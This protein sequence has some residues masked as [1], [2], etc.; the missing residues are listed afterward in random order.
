MGEMEVHFRAAIAA[1]PNVVPVNQALAGS[2][3]VTAC[4][5]GR[6][7][8]ETTTFAPVEASLLRNLQTFDYR[9]VRDFPN[10]MNE[11]G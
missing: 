10:T 5:G 9:K 3:E 1:L 8:L 2:V 7:R 6:S 11:L 4:Y